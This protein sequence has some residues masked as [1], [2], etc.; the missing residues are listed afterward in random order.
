MKRIDKY[1]KDYGNNNGEYKEG[2][3][4]SLCV[5]EIDIDIFNDETAI[6]GSSGLSVGCNGITCKECWDI[7]F[8]DS[9]VVKSGEA[10]G[11]RLID[12]LIDDIENTLKSGNMFVQSV[13]GTTLSVIEER[14]WSIDSEVAQRCNNLQHK[15]FG[16]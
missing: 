1:M 2:I 4:N 14:M 11:E 9:D 6:R 16:E 5:S 7:E 12:L 3:V 15:I 13:L 8:N 10:E